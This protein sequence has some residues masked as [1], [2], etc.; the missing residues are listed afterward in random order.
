VV[1]VIRD[2]A[3]SPPHTNGL[4]V[5]ARL[6]QCAHPIQYIPIGIASAPFRFCPLLSR[7]EYIDQRAMSGHVLG[8]TPFAIKIAAYEWRSGPPSNKWFLRPTP[9]HIPNGITIGSAVFRIA[10]GGDRQT[11]IQITLRRM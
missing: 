5:F 2:K 10:H 9:V 11:D 3:A 1:K 8:R 7:F 6:R 4:A